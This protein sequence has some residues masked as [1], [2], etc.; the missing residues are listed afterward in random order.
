MVEGTGLIGEVFYYIRKESREGVSRRFVKE[1]RK[2]RI[3]MGG[4]RPCLLRS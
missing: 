3:V 4:R 1:S 2:T